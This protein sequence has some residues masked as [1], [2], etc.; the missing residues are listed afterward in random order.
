MVVYTANYGKR[1]YPIPPDRICG[2]L[3]GLKFVYFTD[4]K[5][6]DYGRNT[7]P[8]PKGWE[9]RLEPGKFYDPRM[10]AKWYKLHSHELFPDEPSMWIDAHYSLRAQPDREFAALTAEKPVV[11]FTHYYE[12]LER[13]YK[14]VMHR[15]VDSYLRKQIRA[16]KRQYVSEGFDVDTSP[17]Y[18]GAMLFR[19]PAAEDFNKLW[20]NEIMKYD[21]RRDQLSLPYALWESGVDYTVFKNA[22]QRVLK[23]NK[24]LR[25]CHSIPAP[26]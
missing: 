20:W 7:N 22:D 26:A 12:T 10:S 17:C 23:V 2:D 5:Y 6:E 21:H 8:T 25:P 11:I 16:Q 18:R 13:E 14:V 1:D 15:A 19:H 9:V 3:K 4:T 24:H